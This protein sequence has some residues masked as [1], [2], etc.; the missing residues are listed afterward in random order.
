MIVQALSPP[1]RLYPERSCA[2][3]ALF[4]ATGALFHLDCEPSVAQA[5]LEFPISSA[6]RRPALDPFEGREGGSDTAVI[7]E[8]SMIARA[9]KAVGPLSSQADGIELAEAVN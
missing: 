3:A 2:G 6:T 5:L 7:I 8:A 1:W 9:L 4:Q